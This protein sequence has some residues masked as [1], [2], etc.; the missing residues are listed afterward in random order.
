MN[1]LFVNVLALFTFG[2]GIIIIQDVAKPE[3]NFTIANTLF[4][5]SA[6]LQGLFC[7]SLSR[8]VTKR[9][10]VGFA[11]A[12][13]VFMA[14]FEYMRRNGTFE[15]R[16]VV[17]ATL[18]SILYMWQILAIRK[19]RKLDPSSQ[20]R[21]FL[22]ASSGELLMALCRLAVLGAQTIA[23]RDVEQIPQLLILFT[24][25][26]LVMNTLSFIAIGG[27][28]S[29]RI[30]IENVRSEF[31]NKEIKDLLHERELLIGSLLKANKTAA[32]G[33]LSAS[34]AH[35][36]NQPLG[37]SSLNI[38]FLQKKLADGQLPPEQQKEVLD[39][40]LAD[41]ERAANIIRSLRSIFAEE[42][43]QLE[44]LNIYHLIES[45]L[46]IVRPECTNKKIQIEV[47]VPPIYPFK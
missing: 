17:M 24:I 22:Y 40:L 16:T 9:E 7:Q 46:D 21:Y 25:F 38:Q 5:V 15:L 23:I 11:L 31:E 27:Y 34:I 13:L 8:D 1:S 3:F 47:D 14:A 29:E 26:Q 28:W 4:I 41:N 18:A 19:K 20:L 43:I 6:A 42:A 30:S 35:E 39:T 10:L 32:T 36:L 44:N 37:A 2:G 45:I 33:A 12:T